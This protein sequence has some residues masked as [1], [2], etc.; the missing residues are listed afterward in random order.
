VKGKLLGYPEYEE[1]GLKCHP[2]E[3][4]KPQLTLRQD[5]DRELPIHFIKLIL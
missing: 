2:P 1:I 3:S 5:A 4:E